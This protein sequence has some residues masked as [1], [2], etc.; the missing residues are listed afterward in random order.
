MVLDL[1][2]V[3]ENLH[4]H[5][6]F[7]INL[8]MNRT[9]TFENNMLVAQEYLQNQTG[10][11]ST[12]SGLFLT[13]VGHTNK[14]TPDFPD[15]VLFFQSYIA[16]CAPGNVGTLRSDGRREVIIWVMNLHPKS[17]GTVSYCIELLRKERS[18]IFK[19]SALS[20]NTKIFL[21]TVLYYWD[22]L[23]HCENQSVLET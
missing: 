15:F 8:T 21:M 4:D 3:G 13:G 23:N 5:P 1:P 12:V 16:S 6:A 20:L 7:V 17:K 10:P 11:M 2:G 19:F 14:T 9:D 18:N 22:M